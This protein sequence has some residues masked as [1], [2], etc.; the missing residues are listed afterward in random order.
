MYFNLN[1]LIY[2][3]LIYLYL[4]NKYR[5]ESYNDIKINQIQDTFIYKNKRIN[6]KI[7]E[8]T[9]PYILL[10][11]Y[12]NKE[13]LD[14][15]GKYLYTSPEFKIIAEKTKYQYVKKKPTKAK[16][17]NITMPNFK[18]NFY[19]YHHNKKYSKY[20]YETKYYTQLKYLKDFVESLPFFEE[21]GFI[22]IW[23]DYNGNSSTSH[24][25][26]KYK[27]LTDEFVWLC[28][29]GYKKLYIMKNKKK[30]SIEKNHKCVWF[31]T[32]HKH[33]IDYTGNFSISLR[34]DGKFTNK[35]KQIIMQ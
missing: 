17:I 14:Q 31:N 2:L 25:D 20:Y 35:F 8:P 9:R 13:K 34:V 6:Y 19:N 29:Y 22:R 28:P 10:D 12:I 16:Q 3:I 27:N 21:I 18:H 15:L 5:Q 33:G 1:I 26:H 24:I 23:I 11:Q 30:Y 4:L 32:Q 7:N